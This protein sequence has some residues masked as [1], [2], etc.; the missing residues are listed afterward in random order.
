MYKHPRRTAGILD[1]LC[2]HLVSHLRSRFI[3]ETN[4]QGL[5]RASVGMNNFEARKVVVVV[6]IEEVGGGGGREGCFMRE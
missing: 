2:Y 1:I 5:L 6:V 4:P 3:L